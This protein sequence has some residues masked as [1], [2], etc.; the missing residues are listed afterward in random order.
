MT[1]VLSS[2]LYFGTQ[3][4][5]GGT[6]QDEEC[7]VSV[8]LLVSVTVMVILFQ[9]E[10]CS[11]CEVASP[12]RKM[13]VRGLC[14]LS[15]FDSL[16]TYVVTEKGAVMYLGYWSSVILY[17]KEKSAWMWYDRYM[18]Y[19]YYRAKHRVAMQFYQPI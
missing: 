10:Y 15:P 18:N 1:P 8:H 16:N 19:L 2:R 4:L 11:L 6:I 13:S 17:D 7:S 3:M 5:S 12:S 9:T 14:P